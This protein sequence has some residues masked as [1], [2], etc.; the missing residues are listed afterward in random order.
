MSEQEQ[1]ISELIKVRRDKLEELRSAGIDPFG[2]RFDRNATALK[3][4]ENF[5]EMEG[6]TVKIAGRIMA[7]R[8]HGKAGFAN[9]QDLSGNIQLYF[10]QNDLGEENYELFKKLDIG[11]ILGIEGEVFVPAKEKLAF[12]SE[13]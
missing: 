10:R 12:T 3:I 9:L 13:N 2:Q 8:R 6:Q 11:D 4:L 5:T 1:N 7:K